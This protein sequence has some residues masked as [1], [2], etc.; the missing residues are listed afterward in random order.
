MHKR[1]GS[2]AP[3]SV[4]SSPAAIGLCTPKHFQVGSF[5]DMQPGGHGYSEKS[6]FCLIVII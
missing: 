1:W 2:C 5:D 4:F 6:D 3:Q